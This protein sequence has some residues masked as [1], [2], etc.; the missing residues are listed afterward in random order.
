M[1]L[2]NNIDLASHWIVCELT[3]ETRAFCLLFEKPAN[4]PEWPAQLNNQTI[5]CLTA[6][7]DALHRLSAVNLLALGEET[8]IRMQKNGFCQ[9]IGK[10]IGFLDA[11]SPI[12]IRGPKGGVNDL[13][14][15][16]V[17][18]RALSV[19]WGR[20]CERFEEELSEML[21]RKAACVKHWNAFATDEKIWPEIE[22]R[23][24]IK[25]LREATQTTRVLPHSGPVRI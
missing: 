19:S 10:Q 14:L 6:T 16:Q 18:A 3:D 2:P 12:E 8:R 1:T 23:H 4:K 20:F 24:E 17:R 7:P 11:A 5:E 15:V 13:L 21:Q 22:S 25:I 9:R